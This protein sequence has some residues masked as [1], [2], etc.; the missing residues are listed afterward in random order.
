MAVNDQKQA[1]ADERSARDRIGYIDDRR[2]PADVIEAAGLL[3]EAVIALTYAVLS[4]RR[5][6][7]K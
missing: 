6:L 1:S 7:K 4:I 5:T 2:S 3:T